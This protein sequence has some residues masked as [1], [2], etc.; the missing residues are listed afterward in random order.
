M[1]TTVI[2]FTVA[3]EHDF[4]SRDLES[5]AAQAAD[6]LGRVFAA[7]LGPAGEYAETVEVGSSLADRDAAAETRGD[8]RSTSKTIAS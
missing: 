4:P 6:G 8:V 5:I 2:S 3:L 1:R 7:A